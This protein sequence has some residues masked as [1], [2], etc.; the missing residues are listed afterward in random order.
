M[1]YLSNF[2]NTFLAGASAIGCIHGLREN[3]FTG[4]IKMV[5]RSHT[6]PYDVTKLSKSFKNINYD[7]LFLHKEDYYDEYDIEYMLGRRVCYV[8]NKHGVDYIVLED[9]L[10]LVSSIINRIKSYSLGKV[11]A[12]TSK[13]LLT[14]TV[15][16][17]L[18]RSMMVLCWVLA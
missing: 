7:D 1:H 16:Y 6:L 14:L 13:S 5:S 10:R 8:N 15:I 11:N 18:F 2:N 12:S 3:G 9:G 17:S 4:E